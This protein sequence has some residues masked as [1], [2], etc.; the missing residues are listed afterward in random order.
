MRHSSGGL[1]YVKGAGFE[2]DGWAQV[3]MNL[4]NYQKT[5]VFR[6]VEL[7]RREAERYGV[8]IMKSELI[9]LI[10]QEAMLDA[11]QWY[12][13]LDDFEA[14]Q[15]LEVRM[16][17]D[18]SEDNDFIDDLASGEPLPGGGAAAAQ[19]GVMGAALVAMMGRVTLGKKKYADVEKDM[20]AII[21]KS[22]GLRSELTTAIDADVAAFTG[23]MDA[24][25]LPKG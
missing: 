3:S 23:V 8:G 22:D 9:G 16:Q 19:S 10:P 4:T 2:V 15:V 21:E 25:R 17:G 12:L 13:Q 7:I 18:A 5:P 1:A 14:D 11:A 20:Q 6:V 24:F